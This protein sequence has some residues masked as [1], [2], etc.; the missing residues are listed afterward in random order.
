VPVPAGPKTV[1]RLPRLRMPSA[2]GFPR[3]NFT[4]HIA[5]LVL[6]RWI[7]GVYT[8]IIPQNANQTG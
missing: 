2:Q 4:V 5:E 8:D 3:S 1:D 6:A 7:R